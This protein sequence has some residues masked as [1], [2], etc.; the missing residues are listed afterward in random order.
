MT[1]APLDAQAHNSLQGGPSFSL[2]HRLFRLAWTVFWNSLGS[3]T[4][5]PFH[6]WRRF[7][8]CCFGARIHP[9]AKVYPRVKVWYP[10]NLTMAEYS[11]L[12]PSVDC[13]CMDRIEIG[14][15][16]YVS[17]EAVLCGGTHDVDNP[18]FQ[19]VIKPIRL[20]TRAWVAQRAF[21]GP[22]VTVGDYAVLGACGVT[23]RDLEAMTIYAGNPALP[24]RKR[25][26]SSRID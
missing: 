19:L 17:Q 9:T 15:Y 13:Y 1:R 18:Y 3:W 26:E 10:P 6:K 14:P 7:L 22:G 4:P 16:A 2:R 23:F 25:K 11:C 12:G 20:G 8:L 21:V 5:R 24:L